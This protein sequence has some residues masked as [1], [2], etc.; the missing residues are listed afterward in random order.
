VKAMLDANAPL[1]RVAEEHFGLFLRHERGL[2]SYKRTIT[3]PRDF[4]TVV[5]LF[6]GPAGKGKSTLMTLLSKEL[7]TVYRAPQAKGSGA[8]FDDYDGQDVFVWDE[9]DGASTTPT[10]FNTIADRFECVLP[11]HGGAGHQMV[12]KYLFIGTNYHPKYWWRKR[13]AAQLVQTTRRIDVVLKVGF[14]ARGKFQKFEFW[15]ENAELPGS[16]A[17]RGCR[18]GGAAADGCRSFRKRQSHFLYRV[19]A[20]EQYCPLS[21]Y[22]KVWLPAGS[23]PEA[24][25]EGRRRQKNCTCFD[26]VVHDH[27]V[28]GRIC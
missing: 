3:K 2:K 1:K 16:R 23:P 19:F 18:R 17:S 15:R 4:K 5:F 10:M 8:Y 24:P 6:V 26:Q 27:D 22:L 12:S 14:G 7:G 21:S 13:S 11:V 28:Q 20:N 9:F 25:P